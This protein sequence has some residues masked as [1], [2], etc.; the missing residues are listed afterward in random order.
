MACLAT[1]SYEKIL[2]ANVSSI[3]NTGNENSHLN[4]DVHIHKMEFLLKS[5]RPEIEL[6]LY[7]VFISTDEMECIFHEKT[8]NFES[9]MSCH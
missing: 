2:W 5:I 4:C 9:E 7:L 1:K 6:K 8:I 3:F